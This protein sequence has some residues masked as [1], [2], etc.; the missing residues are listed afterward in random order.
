[1]GKTKRSALRRVIT[2]GSAL[3]LLA[4]A[5]A[6]SDDKKAESTTTAP[7]STEAP[8]TS[9]AETTA[10]PA[11]TEAPATTEAPAGP[12]T[13]EPVK[14][15]VILDES[16]SFGITYPT[17]RAGLEAKVGWINDHG[18]L[19]GSN[20]PVEVV[21]C[22]TQFDPNLATKCARDAADDESVVAVAANVTNFADTINP[23]LEAANLASFGPWGLA[24]ADQTSPVSF[25]VMALGLAATGS[26]A[27]V[28][29]DVAGAKNISIGYA[30]VPSALEG[31]KI[32]EK[33]LEDRGVNIAVKVPVPLGKTDLA[34]EA[35]Q[36]FGEGIDGVIFATDP[37][38]AAALAA[39]RAQLKSTVPIAASGGQ[40]NSASIATLG[41]AAEGILLGAWFATDDW[42]V[43]GVKQYLED[44]GKYTKGGESDDLGKNAWIA[45]DLLNLAAQ[46]TDLSR[47]ALLA[48]GGKI[49]A[50]DAGGFMP[51]TDFSKPSVAMGG[52][53]PRLF[54]QFVTYAK[55]SGGKVVGV[56]K[57]FHQLLK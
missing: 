38:A 16:D 37:G 27:G 24:P 49:S 57:E 29:A 3:A 10:A 50:Y 13:G 15:V 44:L 28:A 9:A 42:D 22:V 43:P 40:F 47:A 36:L 26:M 45:F 33:V 20:R 5:A 25:P 23:I 52:T 41:E 19:G 7:A 46:G 4:G 21:Y 12:A 6:C 32:I 17:T 1:M 2:A 34:A 31:V 53:A 18:G 14:V 55:I 56:D 8:A 30:D 39:L 48:S 11:V 54:N 51:M 35:A